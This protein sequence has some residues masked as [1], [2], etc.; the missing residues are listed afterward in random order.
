MSSLRALILQGLRFGVVGL[1][2]TAVY[3]SVAALTHAMGAPPFLANAIAYA[4]AT[5]VSYLGHFHWTFG[6]STGHR[7]ALLR[8]LVVSGA[9]FLL[10][11]AI[12]HAVTEALAAPFWVALIAVIF[13]VPG[14]SWALGRYW[15]FR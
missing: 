15:T 5:G 4:I 8:F 12:I 14:L 1:W 6:R 9:G 10:S 3:V 2:S 7:R 13:V 11:A